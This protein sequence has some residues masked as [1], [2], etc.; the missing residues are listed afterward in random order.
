MK[1]NTVLMATL[2]VQFRPCL[3]EEDGMML[4]TQLQD[5]Q[6][7]FGLHQPYRKLAKHLHIAGTFSRQNW[8][9]LRWPRPSNLPLGPLRLLRKEMF[10][11]ASTD[12]PNQGARFVACTAALHRH[13]CLGTSSETS[14][15]GAVCILSTKTETIKQ[16]R[17]CLPDLDLPASPTRKQKQGRKA[18]K[19]KQTCLTFTLTFRTSTFPQTQE[20]TE[21]QAERLKE[22]VRAGKHGLVNR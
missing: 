15:S 16:K 17:T 9:G 10:T 1:N 8:M 19:Q 13:T 4:L 14:T 7:Q 3:V 22:S 5:S 6:A 11:E 21:V 12:M 2:P 20:K 18:L